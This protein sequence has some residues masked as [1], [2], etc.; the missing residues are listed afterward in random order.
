MSSNII[1]LADMKHKESWVLA[2]QDLLRDIRVEANITQLE[3]AKKLNKPQ[4][5]VSK[6]EAGERKLDIIEIYFICESMGIK[7]QDFTKRLE[8]KFRNIDNES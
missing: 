5:F 6:Y 1:I 8:K 4:S 3:L 2:L 7:F